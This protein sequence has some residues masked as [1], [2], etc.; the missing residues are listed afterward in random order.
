M[1]WTHRSDG[2]PRLSGAGIHAGC[3]EVFGTG[4]VRSLGDLKG[5]SVAVPALGSP[6]QLFVASMAAYVGLSPL[7]DI[8]WVT[9][10]PAESMRLLADG[11]STRW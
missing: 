8:Q 9:H 4:T 3:Y 1:H 10:S 7:R 2:S 6:H 5:K 11:R